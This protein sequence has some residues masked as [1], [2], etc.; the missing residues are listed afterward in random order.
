MEL[1]NQDKRHIMKKGNLIVYCFSEL[2]D[3]NY[4]F[5]F[6]DGDWVRKI[7]VSSLDGILRIWNAQTKEYERI[8][9]STPF[10]FFESKS[11]YLEYDVDNFYKN[12]GTI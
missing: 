1:S 6:L 11:Y 2:Y 7:H 10:R 5:Y 9:E 12:G 4:H 8:D 3:T